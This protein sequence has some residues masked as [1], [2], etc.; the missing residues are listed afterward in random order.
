[1]LSPKQG[2]QQFF[3]DASGKLAAEY[4]T[5]VEAAQDAKV[6]YLTNDHLGSPRINTDA[7]G[8]ATARPAHP[9]GGLP[10]TLLR[11]SGIFVAQDAEPKSPERVKHATGRLRRRWA[12]LCGL[13]RFVRIVRFVRF[14]RIVLQAEAEAGYYCKALVFENAR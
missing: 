7:S 12:F 4:S 9:G 13:W 3:Y 10:P 5:I 8:A 6:S 14:V 1:M 11:R 2:K